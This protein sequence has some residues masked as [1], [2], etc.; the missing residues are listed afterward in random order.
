[1]FKTVNTKK[2]NIDKEAF[3][4]LHKEMLKAMSKDLADNTL[5]DAEKYGEITKVKYSEDGIP[6]DIIVTVKKII[7]GRIVDVEMSVKNSTKDEL[8]LA[9]VENSRLS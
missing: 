5:F 2:V 4:F 7:E 6:E 9:F 1:M 3:D 8:K